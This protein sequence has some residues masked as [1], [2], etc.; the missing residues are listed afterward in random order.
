MQPLSNSP[1]DFENAKN[2]GNGKDV[3]KCICI[4]TQYRH[5]DLI[6]HPTCY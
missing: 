1:Q 2:T 5:Q 3:D 6:L 4:D